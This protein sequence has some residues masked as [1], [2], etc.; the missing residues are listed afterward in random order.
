MTTYVIGDIHGRAQ[1]LEQLIRD[2]PWDIKHDKIIFLGDLIDR[3]KQSPEVIDLVMD[4]MKENPNVVVL[5]GNHEQMMLDCLEYG[6]LQWLIPENG[7]QATIAS[8]GINLEEVEDIA[9]IKIPEEHLEFI[10][11]LSF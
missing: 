2:V 1:L 9:D 4:L 6:E 7:G 10:N 3:G 11:S 5:R 8:Y